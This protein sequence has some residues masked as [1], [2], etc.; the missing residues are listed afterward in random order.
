M[1]SILSVALLILSST[2]FSACSETVGVPLPAVGTAQD[3]FWPASALPSGFEYYFV[4]A[5]TRTSH[6]LTSSDGIHIRDAALGN[7]ITMVVHSDPDSVLV[8]S[9]GTNSIFSLPSGY[10]FGRV[11]PADT[12]PIVTTIQDT[13]IVDTVIYD[14][15]K[16]ANDT[17]SIQKYVTKDTTIQTIHPGDT[18]LS[19]L[20]LFYTAKLDSGASWQ[21]GTITGPLFPFGIPVTATVLDRVDSLLIPPDSENAATA[22]TSF[23]ESFRIRYV[24]GGPGDSTTATPVY[25]LAYYSKGVGPVLIQQ[26]MFING[27]YAVTQRAQLVRKGP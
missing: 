26:Y 27:A 25:W 9:M 6:L 10:F 5:G 4:R 22:D 21:A 14:T 8:D 18:A 11:S 7:A 15:T 17:L 3:Y 23:G 16:H 1:K 2:T 20:L 13:F 24:P 12:V 19:G